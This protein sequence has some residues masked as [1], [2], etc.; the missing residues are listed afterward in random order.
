M[1][2]NVNTNMTKNNKHRPNNEISCTPRITPDQI[3][4]E[5]TKLSLARKQFIKDLE[6][7]GTDEE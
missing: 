4:D 3:P 6:A 1:E 7:E 2:L 5:P